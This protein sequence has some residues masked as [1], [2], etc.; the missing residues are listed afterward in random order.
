MGK[1]TLGPDTLQ[2]EVREGTGLDIAFQIRVVTAQTHLPTQQPVAPVTLNPF[3]SAKNMSL[4]LSFW[5]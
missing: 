2:A 4:P 3:C 5:E 1:F